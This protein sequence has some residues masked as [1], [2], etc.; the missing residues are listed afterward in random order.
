MRM[1]IIEDEQD[2][3]SAL[4]RGLRK[5]QYAV[6]IAADGEQG[7]EMAQI[8]DYDLLILDLNLPGMDGLEVCRRLRSEKP[9][10][11]ILMLTARVRLNERVTGLDLG[12]DDY[13]SKPFHL[14][15]L[16]ARIRALLRRDVRTRSPLLRCGDLTLDPA[17]I[18]ACQGGR[19]LA[20]TAKEFSILDYLVRHQGEVVSQ[21]DL[22]EH[23]WDVSANTFTNAVRVHITSLRRKLGD[24]AEE[25]RYIETIVGKGYRMF[26]PCPPEVLS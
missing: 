25:P 7:Y 26:A 18:V 1:L 14:D 21:Q 5:H 3:A 11:L 9:S 22:L 2:L 12:A 16:M 8:N 4:A 23:V 10:L 17:T 13:L 6:D 24:D 20:L 19:R 15:E